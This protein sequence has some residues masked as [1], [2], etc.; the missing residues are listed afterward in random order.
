MPQEWAR[1]GFH[2]IN[3]AVTERRI[4]DYRF[5]LD[6]IAFRKVFGEDCYA[7]RA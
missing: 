5:L 3:C 4:S 2:G 6:D 7:K 1:Q